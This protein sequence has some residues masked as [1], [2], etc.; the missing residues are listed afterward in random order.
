MVI[1]LGGTALD[2]TATE[3]TWSKDFAGVAQ[4]GATYS[5]SADSGAIDA[6]TEYAVSVTFKDSAGADD[7]A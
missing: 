3:G 7:D 4:S 5:I 2:S 1:S 6:G